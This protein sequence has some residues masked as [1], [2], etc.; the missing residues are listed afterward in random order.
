MK[1]KAAVLFETKQ[2]LNLEEIDVGDLKHGQVL[3]NVKYTGLCHSQVNEIQGLKGE[4]RFLPHTLGH[5]GSGVVRAVGDG[6]TKVSVGDHVILSWIKSSG[7]DAGGATYKWND[8]VVNSGPIS[9]FMEQAVI[10]ENRLVKIPKSFSLKTAALLGCALPTGGGIVMNEMQL[11]TGDSLAIFGMGGIGLSALLVAKVMGA[12]PLIAVD[13]SEEKLHMAEEL[14]ATHTLNIASSSFQDDLLEIT[15]NQGLKF[16]LEAAGR[17]D[18]MEKAFA[19]IAPG[20][21]CVIAGNAPVGEKISLC[22]FD[23]IKGK[24]LVGTWGGKSDLEKDI[25]QYIKWIEEGKLN[26]DAI[27]SDEFP[28]DEIQAAVDRL[29]SRKAARCMIKL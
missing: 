24:R 2:P 16:A 21:L 20:G 15:N 6:V 25:A 10:S 3:V 29:L 26:I 23:F 5:E 17:T 22:P 9:T 19:S 1:T 27:V 4:D 18:V 14:G 7:I 28:L 12:N 11:K 8:Q 13:I